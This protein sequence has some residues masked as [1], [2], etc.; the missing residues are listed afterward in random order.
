MESDPI[1]STPEF[2]ALGISGNAGIGY[3]SYETKVGGSAYFGLGV[4]P[5]LAGAKVKLS[6]DWELK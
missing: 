1:Y 4:T 2:N 6:I 5:V 3:K